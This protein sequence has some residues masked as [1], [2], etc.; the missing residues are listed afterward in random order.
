MGPPLPPEGP[1]EEAELP[2]GDP[3]PLSATTF[4][5][6]A[7]NSRLGPRRPATEAASRLMRALWAGRRD[8]SVTSAR[9]ATAPTAPVAA[10]ATSAPLAPPR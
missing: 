5:P 2:M 1:L 7:T 3:P 10:K 9:L 6:Q 8:A 4:P